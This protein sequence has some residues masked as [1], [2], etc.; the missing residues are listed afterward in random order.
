M[1]VLTVHVLRILEAR[2]TCQKP[3]DAMPVVQYLDRPRSTVK[4]LEL[5]CMCIL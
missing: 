3:Q 5:R 2:D 1:I 4:S